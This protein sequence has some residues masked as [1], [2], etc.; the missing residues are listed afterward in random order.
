MYLNSVAGQ[1]S[2][3][4]IGQGN[5]YCSFEVWCTLSGT[6]SLTLSSSTTNN[7]FYFGQNIGSSAPFRVSQT[8]YCTVNYTWKDTATS[9]MQAVAACQQPCDNA[10]VTCRNDGSTSNIIMNVTYKSCLATNT[11]GQTA[12]VAHQH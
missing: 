10:R 4:T 3:V 1:S 9:G 8:C 2:T 7:S 5:D 12:H 6:F 11:T